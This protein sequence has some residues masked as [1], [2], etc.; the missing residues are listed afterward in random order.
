MVSKLNW[1][2]DVHFTH[3]HAEIVT[4]TLSAS[5]NGEWTSHLQSVAESVV[6]RNLFGILTQNSINFFNVLT[7]VY[8]TNIIWFTF[9]TAKLHNHLAIFTHSK[10]A[11]L[12]SYCYVKIMNISN[13][14]AFHQELIPHLFSTFFYVYI[15]YVQFDYLQQRRS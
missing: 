12:T 5:I 14:W 7:C 4:F 1:K 6:P 3:L 13:G 8:V 10:I 15:L 2:G 9:T 11:A